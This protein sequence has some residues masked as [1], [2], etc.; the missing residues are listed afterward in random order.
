MKDIKKKLHLYI[1]IFTLLM[2][3]S[4]IILLPRADYYNRL[5][6]WLLFSISLAAAL[7]IIHEYR[8]LKIAQLIIENKIVCIQLMLMC[9]SKLLKNSTGEI[10]KDLEKDISGV[11]E[12]SLEVFVSCFGIM[13]GSKI[14]KF[15]QEGIML[16]AVEIGLDYLTVDY[17]IDENIKNIRII[18]DRPDNDILESIIEKFRYETGIIPVVKN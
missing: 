7:G 16:K 18:Y 4:I 11:A 9:D 2:I 6:V 13:I 10:V 17:G 12:E 14:I 8:K 3:A 15:N 5:L 1:G